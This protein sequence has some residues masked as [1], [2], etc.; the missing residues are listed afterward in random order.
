[1]MWSRPENKRFAGKLMIVGGHANSLSAPAKAFTAAEKAGI[2]VSKV[3]L[4]DVTQKILGRSFVEAEFVASNPSG[5][6]GLAALGHMLDASEWADAVLFAGDFGKNSETAILLEKFIG[7]YIGILVIAGD[8]VE[9]FMHSGSLVLTRPKT[10]L[11]VEFPKLQKLAKLNFPQP[12]LLHSADIAKTIEIMDL[13][14]ISNDV[15]FLTEKDGRIILSLKGQSSVTSLSGADEVSHE[16]S[17]YAAVWWLQQSKKPFE[18][19]TT[20]V[21]DCMNPPTGK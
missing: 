14:T 17:S 7:K 9:P 19:I 1:M 8:A 10:L 13:W 20:A 16:L 15:G 3:V 11:V 2:G 6:L 12:P 21:Y 4:P 5:S 18:A